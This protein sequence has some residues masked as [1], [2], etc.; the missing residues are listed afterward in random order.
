MISIWTFSGRHC[1]FRKRC[2]REQ[3]V[4]S[5]VGRV[6]ENIEVRVHLIAKNCDK[7]LRR[8][9]QIMKKI[10]PQPSQVRIFRVHPLSR[11]AVNKD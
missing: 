4:F 1:I 8:S 9:K 10:L 5:V 6:D 3:L 11:E 7:A 2:R